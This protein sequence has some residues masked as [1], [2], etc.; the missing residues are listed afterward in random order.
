M[1]R[2]YTT[3]CLSIH[4]L[5]GIWVV[6][7]F[8]LLWIVPHV[9]LDL[10]LVIQREVWRTRRKAAEKS[11][12]V[13][14]LAL[15]S[16]LAI[17]YYRIFR[18]PVQS[19]GQIED[20]CSFGFK[21]QV[22]LGHKASQL[23]TSSGFKKELTFHPRAWLL[24]FLVL[25]TGS[26]QLWWMQWQGSDIHSCSFYGSYLHLQHLAGSLWNVVSSG[27]NCAHVVLGIVGC[28]FPSLAILVAWCPSQFFP[29]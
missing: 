3:I 8:G 18:K 20:L 22:N 9:N 25:S 13:V 11:L 28:S 26:L 2:R 7:T 29:L 21:I 19:W 4:Q 16:L 23:I 27:T 15:S 6:S 5:I 24:I 10:R 17:G 12:L 1:C 14:L